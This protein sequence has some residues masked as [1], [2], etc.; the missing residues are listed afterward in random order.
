MQIQ[1]RRRTR[2]K[3]QK[4][5]TLIINK[6]ISALCFIKDIFR[7]IIGKNHDTFNHFSLHTCFFSSILYTFSQ[8]KSK[9]NIQLK[10]NNIFKLSNRSTPDS[11]SAMHVKHSKYTAKNFTENDTTKKS[12]DEIYSWSIGYKKKTKK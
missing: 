11:L 3:A 12:Y 8:L 4:L 9:A 2:L 5:Q 1:W 7:F 6:W 10:V